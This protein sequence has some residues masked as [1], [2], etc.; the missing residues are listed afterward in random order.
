[1]L[2]PVQ[3]GRAAACFLWRAGFDVT[4][5]DGGL[6]PEPEVAGDI[7]DWHKDQDDVRLVSAA[8]RRTKNSQRAN[9]DDTEKFFLGSDFVYRDTDYQLLESVEGAD[10]RTSLALGGL[11]N[12][13]GAASLPLTARDTGGWPVTGG[14]LA[15]YYKSLKEIIDVCGEN[16]GLGSHFGED[17]SAP[18]FDLGLQGG[19]L[20][21]ALAPQQS[22][23]K[24]R[25]ISF[26]RARLA[27]ANKYSASPEGCVSCGHCMIGCP[28][29]AIFN[30]AFVIE[31]LQARERFI[32]Q[33]E[34][35]VDRVMENGQG[36][37]V[38]GR[39][40]MIARRLR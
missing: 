28:H 17:F 5:L 11:S 15:P 3:P 14:D 9:S 6:T 22:R 33:A 13:W 12:V 24:A 18:S 23:L 21:Q 4:V 39:G 2:G 40:L 8:A 35:I 36:V 34:K 10:I 7:A 25:G 20:L 1:M 19:A 26:G 16:D 38:Q 32:Y 30:A 31:E 29:R 27:V 37:S